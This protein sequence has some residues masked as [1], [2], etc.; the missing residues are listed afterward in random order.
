MYNGLLF[1][2]HERGYLRCYAPATGELLWSERLAIGQYHA[3]LVG[4]DGK[5]Y[6]VARN[7]PVTVFAATRELAQLG[8][9][10]LPDPGVLASP[11]LAGGCLLLRTATSLLCIEGERGKAVVGAGATGG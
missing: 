9:N 4:G 1:V 2:L 8:E 11:A 6:A 5:I 3:S 10:P 7:G